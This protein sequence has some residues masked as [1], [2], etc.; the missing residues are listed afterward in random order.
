MR[1][2]VAIVC[3]WW[4]WFGWGW[5]KSRSRSDGVVQHST[6]DVVHNLLLYWTHSKG[7]FRH[8]RC[9]VPGCAGLLSSSRALLDA[10]LHCPPAKTGRELWAAGQPC[11]NLHRST[12]PFLLFFWPVLAAPLLNRI[13][14]L[15]HE[16]TFIRSAVDENFCNTMLALLCE[17]DCMRG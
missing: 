15:V 9:S 10:L 17:C 16:R 1:C 11:K 12:F 14:L 5:Q 6:A 7:A 3:G 13:N 8:R 2:T 4:W